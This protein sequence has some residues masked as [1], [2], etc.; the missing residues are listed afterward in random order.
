MAKPKLDR[1]TLLQNSLSVFKTKGYH[2]TSMQDLATANGLLKGSIYHYISS[3]EELMTEVLEAL[4][5]HYVRKV[6]SIIE[7]ANL[8]PE[9]QLD[10]LMEK[11]EKIYTHEEG[12]DFF[13][14]IGLETLNTNPRF[15]EI[16][17]SFFD[18]WIEVLSHLFVKIG[19]PK[20]EA[21]LRAETTV[22]EIEGAVILMRL[23]KDENYLKRTL[24]N[25]KNTFK[26]NVYEF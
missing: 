17:Q 26:N 21:K 16:I 24:Q 2:A 9:Q 15:S 22:A 3:K 10:A 1:K 25:L 11:A 18:Q 19:T 13:V 20:K 7:D 6:F 23:L 8:S 14:N 5:S 4:K 12:G